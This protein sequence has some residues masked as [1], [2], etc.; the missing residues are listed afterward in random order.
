MIDPKK[1]GTETEA[2]KAA[3]VPRTTLQ[4]AVDRGEIVHVA[5]FGGT[6]LVEIASAKKWAKNRPCRGRKPQ[7]EST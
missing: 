1:Y 4:S 5:T 7:A 2:A 6:R 3:S